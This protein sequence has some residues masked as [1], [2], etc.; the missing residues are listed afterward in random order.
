ML[1]KKQKKT[2]SSFLQASIDIEAL[3]DEE[4]F[5]IIIT[6]EKFEELCGDLFQK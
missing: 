5:N 1:A 3:Q 4:D 6:R 2:L